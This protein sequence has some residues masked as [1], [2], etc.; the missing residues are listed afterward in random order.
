VKAVEDRKGQPRH[1]L[2]GDL[3]AVI[4]AANE[5]RNTPSMS[6][7]VRLTVRSHE[8]IAFVGHDLS[9]RRDAKYGPAVDPVLLALAHTTEHAHHEVVGLVRRVDRR[10]CSPAPSARFAD[11]SWN[12]HM[13]VRRPGG[14]L[15][16]TAPASV[17]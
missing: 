6:R 8:V 1:R 12:L 13:V 16:V 11:L 10:R 4:A 14:W 9:H 2:G 5:P 15:D 7:P 17:S 3:D